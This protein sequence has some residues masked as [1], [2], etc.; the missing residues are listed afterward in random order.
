MAGERV[1]LPALPP[2]RGRAE[3][4]FR[5]TVAAMAGGCLWAAADAVADDPGAL[6][7]A[8]GLLALLALVPLG[9]W[10][11]EAWLDTSS[12]RLC[13]RRGGVVPV[14][15]PW[16][17]VEELGLHDP[18]F[19]I[20]VLRIRGRHRRWSTLLPV[21]ACDRRG[22]RSLPVPVLWQL[23]DE[24]RRWA[25]PRHHPV[26]DQLDAQAD[27]LQHTGRIGDSPVLRDYCVRL[28]PS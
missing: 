17:E 21:V 13:R 27:H 4:T 2:G 14:E 10:L 5:L 19:G 25:P 24:I 28:P 8:V 15:I 20:V 7:W 22:L 6:P 23:A 11:D 16:D 3:R 1:P 26:A 12:G 18:G 9:F